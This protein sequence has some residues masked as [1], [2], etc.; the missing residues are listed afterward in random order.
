MSSIF[1]TKDLSNDC[2]LVTGGAGFIGSHIA[3]YLLKH[4]AK[5]VR[6]LDN[7]ANGFEKNLD[8]LKGYAAFQFIEADIR[9][10]DICRQAC[11]G[12]DYISHQ[13]AL[14]SVPRSIKE[15]IYFNEVNVGGFT[16]MIKAAV[17]SNV[18]KFVYASS[19]SVYGDEPTLPKIEDKVGNCLSPYAAT[20]KTNELYAQVFADVFGIKTIGLRYFNIFGP[21]QDPDGAYAAVIP[22]FVKGIMKRIPVFI[23]GDGEQTRDFTFVE[24]AVQVNIKS[25][26]TENAA[27]F[28]KVY[29][30]AVGE[31]FSVNYLYNACKQY[32]ESNWE[33]VYREPRAG[34]IRNSLADITLAKKLLGY[35]PT[36]KFEAGL[37]DTIDFFKK[38]YS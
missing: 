8:V 31:N 35:Q 16:N 36:R 6:V 37:A 11:E 23:N 10:E 27:A 38:V 24:N 29:N 5:Q 26:L 18:K 1:H 15:P 19:S 9:N 2:F 34:D 30:V 20:K 33:P 14:G 13:A 28:N 7:M 32:L 12:I 22:L 25:M 17:D 3:E 4:G 21:R